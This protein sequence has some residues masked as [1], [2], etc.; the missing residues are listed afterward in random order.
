MYYI[1]TH[2]YIYEFKNRN[3]NVTRK[4]ISDTS[5]SHFLSK[6]NDTATPVK[7]N[8]I[9]FK[10]PSLANLPQLAAGKS[11][12]FDSPGSS[13]LLPSTLYRY[14]FFRDEKII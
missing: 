2:Y 7:Y 9:Y 8:G 11:F 5:N 1:G 12:S 6:S 4:E 14:D 10:L 3:N 13:V